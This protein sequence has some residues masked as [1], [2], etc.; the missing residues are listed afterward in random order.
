MQA[1]IRDQLPLSGS[2]KIITT[3]ETQI[4]S[5]KKQFPSLL[6]EDQQVKIRL[7]DSVGFLVKGASGRRRT[8]KNEW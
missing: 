6:G 1:E 7:I 5:Q 3:A 8:G 4:Y 2:G